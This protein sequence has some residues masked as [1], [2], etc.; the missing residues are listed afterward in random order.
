MSRRGS[1][2][3]QTRLGRMVQ[4]EEITSMQQAVP[5]NHLTLPTKRRV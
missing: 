1:W 3:P 2:E 4:D 5:Y